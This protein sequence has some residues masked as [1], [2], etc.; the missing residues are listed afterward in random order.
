MIHSGVS[1]G[2]TLIAHACAWQG[3]FLTPLSSITEQEFN[4]WHDVPVIPK[5]ITEFQTVIHLSKPKKSVKI[6]C[7]SLPFNLDYLS[8]EAL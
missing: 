3:V 1:T 6:A 4:G 2:K 8:P 7:R 5:K